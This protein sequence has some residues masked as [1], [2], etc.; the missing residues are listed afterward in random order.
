[1]KKMKKLKKWRERSN[2][3]ETT[4]QGTSRDISPGHPGLVTC[5]NWRNE[6]LKSICINLLQARSSYQGSITCC[7]PARR[8]L[9][10]F[11][12]LDVFDGYG[13]ANCP[14]VTVSTSSWQAT[15]IKTCLDAKRRGGAYGSSSPAVRKLLHSQHYSD[16]A[17]WE[18]V[19]FSA[20]SR[21][22]PAACPSGCGTT[23]E[24]GRRIRMTC[25]NVNLTH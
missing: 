5:C 1:M 19:R 17:S 9:R 7:D 4:A 15:S 14:F 10:T 25:C 20:S 16:Q 24:K 12:S 23:D 2:D 22:G 13:C 3:N 18:K 8:Y 6:I 11:A 21:R